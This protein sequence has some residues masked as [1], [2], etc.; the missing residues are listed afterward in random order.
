MPFYDPKYIQYFDNPDNI[1]YNW[2]KKDIDV[3]FNYNDEFSIIKLF[4]KLE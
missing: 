1:D 3:N 4:D 2:I